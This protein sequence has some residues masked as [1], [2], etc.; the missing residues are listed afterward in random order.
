M[1][2]RLFLAALEHL[3]RAA[4]YSALAVALLLAATV[5]APAPPLELRWRPATAA[6][7]RE[8]ERQQLHDALDEYR[9]QHP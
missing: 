7:E 8:Y 6:E 1:N 4:A 3:T 2:R 9:R 5:T